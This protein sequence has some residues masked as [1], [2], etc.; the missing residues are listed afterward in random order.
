[1]KKKLELNI[2]KINNPT[3]LPVPTKSQPSSK[4][5][6]E[7]KSQFSN[8]N[9]LQGA[10]NNFNNT[11]TNS[12][13]HHNQFNTL[14]DSQIKNQ[15]NHNTYN[16]SNS[17]NQNQII[18]EKKADKLPSKGEVVPPNS[19]KNSNSK[20][21]SIKLFNNTNNTNHISISN[22]KLTTG[23]VASNQTCGKPIQNK[24]PIQ[25]LATTTQDKEKQKENNYFE[26][27]EESTMLKT[28]HT[29]H[30][31]NLILSKNKSR[32]T[33]FN[34]II[35]NYNA[36]QQ[37]MQN[38]NLI[39]N[40]NIGSSLYQKSTI[41]NSQ[42]QD[43]NNSN[44]T[45]KKTNFTVNTD[46]TQSIVNNNNINSGTSNNNTFQTNNNTINNN[47][48][49]TNNNANNDVKL[50]KKEKLNNL[51]KLVLS[52]QKQIS[53]T[54]KQLII[55][56]GNTD[57]NNLI[58]FEGRNENLVRKK[59]N[60]D[61]ESNNSNLNSSNKM[62]HKKKS[63]YNL[64]S[65]SRE[66][67]NSTNQTDSKSGSNLYNTNNSKRIVGLK[68]KTLNTS[69][70]PRNQ[71]SSTIMSAINNFNRNQQ[72][73]STMQF[74]Y[75]QITPKSKISSNKDL[76]KIAAHSNNQQ[77]KEKNIENTTD[78]NINNN[79]LFFYNNY[80]ENDSKVL[81]SNIINNT[82]NNSNTNLNLN[83]TNTTHAYQS[84][85]NTF[86]EGSDMIQAFK[87]MNKLLR[88]VNLNLKSNNSNSNNM[89]KDNLD[90][91]QHYENELMNLNNNS[92]KRRKN[93]NAS[94][95]NFLASNSKLFKTTT[96]NDILTPFQSQNKPHKELNFKDSLQQSSLFRNNEKS[97]TTK[98]MNKN[99]LNNMQNASK[100]THLNKESNDN[101]DNNNIET[102]KKKKK[103]HNKNKSKTHKD[104]TNI[105]NTN[106]NYNPPNQQI[107]V[108]NNININISFN[109]NSHL[110]EVE[111]NTE[112]NSSSSN[113]KNNS[114]SSKLLDKNN[115]I[116]RETFVG[117]FKNRK[118]K[119]INV[120]TDLFANESQERIKKYDMIFNFIN[121][122]LKEISELVCNEESA[123]NTDSKGSNDN[124]AYYKKINMN[125]L[126]P[127][128][129]NDAYCVKNL[130]VLTDP[131]T[132]LNKNS[133]INNNNN[134]QDIDFVVSN[135]ASKSQTQIR[136]NIGKNSNNN[137][138][139]TFSR[140]N[141]FQIPKDKSFVVSSVNDE[142]YRHL[143]KDELQNMNLVAG[144]WSMSSFRSWKQSSVL[145]K[146]Q[147]QLEYSECNIPNEDLEYRMSNHFISSNNKQ[148]IQKNKT[149][150]SNKESD[151]FG[152]VMELF[153]KS[154]IINKNN[155]NSNSNSNTSNKSNN[156][157]DQN[158]NVDK[159]AVKNSTDKTIIVNNNKDSNNN[160]KQ[161]NKT[162]SSKI[163]QRK[164][165]TEVELDDD[166]K[167]EI[168]EKREQ[169]C[170]VF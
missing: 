169:N 151:C 145:D 102:K 166:D 94:N 63:L 92:N 129:T 88:G 133:C 75:K 44:R 131:E 2:N 165:Y 56:S 93:I 15:I 143:L 23:F 49:N 33:L 59:M 159:E 139:T 43:T 3:G 117:T 40:Y 71:L 127:I 36:H 66:G 124:T 4:K 27:G 134:N 7:D 54:E 5:Q 41:Y 157:N 47:T 96:K 83:N 74:N 82:I 78:N 8:L 120:D 11:P 122:N 142:F 170:V 116:K 35:N 148:N 115:R 167:L 123:R 101:N 121:S 68:N 140:E 55:N 17:K 91:I 160:T 26:K 37:Q 77:S 137:N 52:T 30:K 155:S 76:V 24:I 42:I 163:I 58:V 104:L 149:I 67:I 114:D 81:N 39:S 45:N 79:E 10:Q 61:S 136:D 97:T 9:T 13:P 20:R 161:T 110:K 34:N 46:K 72:K 21:I 18:S 154:S 146:T 32:D 150:N 141:I 108:N 73:A 38:N 158:N 1:M 168:I 51:R 153:K 50:T 31:N 48:N 89:N 19:V 29:N 106:I 62:K 87:N 12:T 80:N 64:S 132:P 85:S 107:S 138:T 125:K 147:T 156:K 99:S 164:V 130:K 53:L 25:T 113:I 95:D 103:K 28:S 105:L 84:Q 14:S 16:L 90:L 118:N 135:S 152:E 70:T 100:T 57:I 128:F 109:N 111:E 86:L 112:K 60:K 119:D 6:N 98:N 69:K 126:S 65:N 22:K 144:N 162:S